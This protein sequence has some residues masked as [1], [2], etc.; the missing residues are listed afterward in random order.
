LIRL[1][2]WHPGARAAA[3]VGLALAAGCSSTGWA[4][5]GP[6]VQ[7]WDKAARDAWYN[8]DQG[9]R[10][11][12]LKWFE[13]L[14]QPDAPGKAFLDT[15]Y[16]ANFRILPP[17]PG[18]PAGL[19]VGFAVDRIDDSPLVKTQ[20]H[21]LPGKSAKNEKVDWVGLNCAA[22]HTGQLTYKGESLTVDGAPSQFDFQSFVEAVDKSLAETRASANSGADPGRWNRFAGAVLG[23]SDDSPAARASLLTALDK[24]IDWETQAETLNH[25][26]LRYGFGRV[27]AVG[28][29]FNRV[30]M[31]GGAPQPSPNAPN[32]PVSYPHLWNASKETQLQWDGVVTN[33]KLNIG[34]TPFD[35]GA[36]GRNTGE[37]LGVFG[38]AVIAP[39]SG[40]LRVS[41]FRSS[42]NLTNLNDM[43]V[44]VSRLQPPV[45]PEAKFGA[46]G[47][48]A[49]TDASGRRLTPAEVLA[50]GGALF[51]TGCASCHTPRAHY[52]TMKTFAQ[53]GPENL[54]DEWM[55]CNTWA[56]SGN[57]G[58]LAGIPASYVSGAPMGAVE[59]VRVLLA[60]TVIGTLVGKKGELAQSALE[61]IFGVTPLPR[62]TGPRFAPA[63]PLT[64]DELRLQYCMQ[65]Q[66]NPLLAYK[67]RPLEG[68]W[69]TAPYLHN[70]SV[71]TLY[72]L[73]QPP[74][75]R[76]ATF[77]LGTRAFDPAKV[78][79]DTDP[80][81]AGNS[82]TFDTSQAGNSNK[83]HAYGV[84]NL[85]E[86]QRL[87]LL[88]YLK[89][90]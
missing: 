3:L 55:A 79:Y 52:E 67:A 46:P 18:A 50:A 89:S 66:T 5:K 59:P 6:T 68:I 26:D 37:V 70:G 28:H 64:K 42:A 43:E 72:D 7:G 54:T 32:A 47:D 33:A 44:L 49:V 12:P 53:L 63:R 15:G 21:W 74:A 4:P 31:F 86:T 62:V 82:F 61:N 90:L 69:A 39:P 27:D 78:G 58:K 9:S 85:T 41:G 71:P 84:G 19:P 34:V 16:L 22:C 75:K 25:T 10:F 57:S 40:P 20:L 73:L 24:L 83:G 36:A 60:G 29:I 13:A 65:N 2:I 17:W 51:K 14:E 38:E 45:W 30:L 8:A 48:I 56:F 23:P 35:Y 1:N 81:A 88:E 77:R 87:E 11:M 80:A 76:P